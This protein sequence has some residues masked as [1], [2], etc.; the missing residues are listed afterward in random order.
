MT[1]RSGRAALYY[2]ISALG[3]TISKEELDA[4]YPKFLELADRSQVVN[5]NDL[6]ELLGSTLAKTANI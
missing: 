5:D 3:V 4:V 6:K 2:R 1:A